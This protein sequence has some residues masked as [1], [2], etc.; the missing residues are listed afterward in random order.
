MYDCTK[1]YINGE[2]SVSTSGNTHDII[3]PAT[4]ESIGQFTFGTA[5]DVDSAVA[6]ARAAFDT[7]LKQSRLKWGRR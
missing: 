2:W 7:F 5:D 4:E 1:N 6:A 3:N